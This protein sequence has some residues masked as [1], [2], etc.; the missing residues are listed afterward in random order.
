MPHYRATNAL[1]REKLAPRAIGIV[2]YLLYETR[3]LCQRQYIGVAHE[4]NM[5]M[6]ISHPQR[7]HYMKR[8]KCVTNRTRAHNQNAQSIS[9]SLHL[10]PSDSTSITMAMPT[11]KIA[12]KTFQLCSASRIKLKITHNAS[13]APWRMAWR[14]VARYKREERKRRLIKYSRGEKVL[15]RATPNK[16]KKAINARLV[17][18]GTKRVKRSNPAHPSGARIIK[19]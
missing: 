5:W 4:G 11:I 13:N 10:R 3:C 18:G 7:L 2:R 17:C 6:R 12:V 1:R 8:Q 15:V 16:T 19:V 14:M 9:P